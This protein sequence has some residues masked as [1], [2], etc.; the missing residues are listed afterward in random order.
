LRSRCTYVF[1]HRLEASSTAM[2][3]SR[4]PWY[5][6]HDSIIFKYSRDQAFRLIV[7]EDGDHLVLPS[8]SMMISTQPGS[9]RPVG[10]C[11]K[12]PWHETRKNVIMCE[13]NRLFQHRYF[14]DDKS[15][16]D[17]ESLQIHKHWYD[18][19]QFFKN[20]CAFLVFSLFKILNTY[21][22]CNL[23]N[24]AHYVGQRIVGLNY[25]IVYDEAIDSIGGHILLAV[26][27]Y[28]YAHSGALDEFI[29]S[30]IL[31][32]RKRFSR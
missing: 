25:T 11:Q 2:F 4:V 20:F 26:K 5:M 7:W 15:F 1:A 21:W 30:R 3:V 18:H 23:H 16:F 29:L 14:F 24:I 31:N 8:Q 9:A 13:N 10:F 22:L 27:F 6:V 19:Y 28:A 12:F 32:D 17:D